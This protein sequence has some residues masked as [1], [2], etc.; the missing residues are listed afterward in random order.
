[1]THL[2]IKEKVSKIEREIKLNKLSNDLNFKLVNGSKVVILFI[3][4]PIINRVNIKLDP[5]DK[6][7][8]NRIGIYND[9]LPFVIL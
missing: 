5:I 2:T 6:S 9:E 7:F 4:E 1:M 8:K 3:L